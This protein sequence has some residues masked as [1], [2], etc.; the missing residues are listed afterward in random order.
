MTSEIAVVPSVGFKLPKSPKVFFN[1]GPDLQH[2]N[3]TWT[4]RGTGSQ[5]P[6]HRRSIESHSKPANGKAPVVEDGL[7][8]EDLDTFQEASPRCFLDTT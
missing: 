7:L 2:Y 6:F 1:V 3:G 4:S 8:G 5:W